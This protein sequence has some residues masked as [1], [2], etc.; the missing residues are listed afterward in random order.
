MFFVFTT[1]L[2]DRNTRRV[3]IASVSGDDWLS[4]VATSS[5]HTCTL[6][7]SALHFTSLHRHPVDINRM[8]HANSPE[9]AVQCQNQRA[10]LGCCAE[11]ETKEWYESTA[12]FLRLAKASPQKRQV[13]ARIRRTRYHLMHS[14]S[15]AEYPGML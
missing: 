1:P 11:D 8:T 12:R 14:E 5:Q 4:E 7:R 6:K 10:H 9:H 15:L 2:S 13:T 3:P